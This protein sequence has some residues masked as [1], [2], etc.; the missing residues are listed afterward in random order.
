MNYAFFCNSSSTLFYQ[1]QCIQATELSQSEWALYP[2]IV[3]T[4]PRT[5]W[6]VANKVCSPLRLGCTHSI[7]ATLPG[8]PDTPTSFLS[9][10][11]SS[12]R[13][14]TTPFLLPEIPAPAR[15]LKYKVK[16]CAAKKVK[17]NHQNYNCERHSTR[18]WEFGEVQDHLSAAHLKTSSD[19]WETLVSSFSVLRCLSYSLNT[20]QLWLLSKL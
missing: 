17:K 18:D 11:S 4:S 3:S 14:R 9:T 6:D 19:C 20:I 1:Y 16:Y 10:L 2:G 13:E 8:Y 12:T 5:F 15:R 7:L